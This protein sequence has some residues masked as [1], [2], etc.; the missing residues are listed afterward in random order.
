MP[1]W[2]KEQKDAIYKSNSNIIVSAGAGSG[3]TAVLSE[4]VIEKLKNNIHINELLILTFTSAAALEMKE[5]IRKKIKKDEN[6]KEELDLIDEAYI[7]TFDS[8][9]MSIV[10]KYHYL[11]NVG[12]SL[13]IVESSVIEIKKKEI[14]DEILD[15][16]YAKKDPRFLKLITDFC[17]KDDKLI[18]DAILE[19]NNKL[20]L[21]I[22][23]MS[24]LNN[25]I[26]IKYNKDNIIHD[27][28]EYIKNI[29]E[30]INSLKLYI[31]NLSYYVDND[32][33]TNIEESLQPLLNS[34][35]YLE[36]KNNSIIN[37]PRMPRGSSEEAK[38]EKDKIKDKIKEINN[39][40]VYSSENEIYNSIQSTKDYTSILIEIIIKFSN[41]IADYK[42]NLDL[43]EFNDIAIMAI[44]IVSNKEIGEELKQKFKEIMIDEYQDTSDL[45]EEFI[46]KIENNNVYMV[47]DIKQSIYRFRNANP[48]I[49]KNKYDNYTNNKGGIKIDLLKNFRSR[50][51]VLNNINTIFNQIMDDDIG[52]CNYT[53]SHQMIFGNNTYLDEGKTDQNNNFEILTYDYEKTNPFSKEEIEV[54]IIAKDIKN[55]IEN[56][57][58]I[59]DKDKL[60]LRDIK[61]SDI[62]ILIDRSTNF[63]LFKKI[64]TYLQIPLSIYK[65]EKLN[66]DSDILV[67][68][69]LISFII[70]VKNNIIDNEFKYLFTSIS[71][72]FIYNIDDNTIFNYFY[73]NNFT[74]SNLYQKAYNISLEIDNISINE[75]NN[76]V[77]N[78]FNFIENLIKIGN[79]NKS[80]TKIDKIKEIAS[81]LNDMG[82]DI[83]KF[84]DYLKEIMTNDY[85]MT[86]QANLED[87]D[88][89]KIMTIHKSKGLEYHIC[90]FPMLYKPFNL[91]DIK[92]KFNYDN[93]YG[94][95]TPYFD[96]G[97]GKTIYTTLLKNKY[98]KEEVSEKIRLLY[99]ALTRAK[100]KMIMILPNNNNKININNSVI[101]DKEIREKYSSFASIFYS[102]E[103]N[104]HDYYK[105]I[106]INKL[107]LTKEYN[108][109]KKFNIATYLNKNNNKINI[110]EINVVNKVIQEESYSKKSDKLKDKNEI[111]NMEYGTKVHELL[112][113]VD[114][115]TKDT[116]FIKDNFIKDK[117]DK[118]LAKLK[119]DENT[120]I[121]KE[122][123]FIYKKNDINYHGIIDLILEYHDHIDIIDY[124]LKNTID[125]SYIK[126]INGYKNYIESISN[127]K[128]NI[129]L[130]SIINNEFYNHTI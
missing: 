44:N 39:M 1:S 37:L 102:L 92:E 32:Y 41:Q 45:Q 101:V 64:F 38:E 30:N 6:L 34:N 128:V 24:Y 96:N 119:I 82:Y 87:N 72:S 71:R 35:T 49:F 112:E 107:N 104:I 27:I 14:L 67:F 84:N 23:K 51:E 70:K 113:I 129:Y 79:I 59:F 121:Y 58:Q 61:Y 81:N 122:Y 115:K 9:A 62:V 50:T 4:R 105:S 52:G 95:I 93:T 89:V 26:D 53:L 21:K 103:N 108:M 19:I 25:Y 33:I 15:E 28:E 97:I 76:K 43:Y 20:D 16:Y 98:T 117:I 22:D 77:L 114:F 47:G 88:A 80:I 18:K 109:I 10:K 86:Y 69:N 63:E 99:V 94:I 118:F 75:F 36:I 31:K 127:K 7:T 116:N 11:I 73:N 90:Y 83:Y 42:K 5:R 60:I 120:K 56:K 57:Y 111:I 17:V 106:D 100:E 65:D 66:T 3:K 85:L 13:S 40:C 12:K 54:F 55:K 74:N 46:S 125:N 29:K 126:Q 48:Y 130:Y 110:E 78:E 2:T 123:E 68:K 8:F 124:K 91:L